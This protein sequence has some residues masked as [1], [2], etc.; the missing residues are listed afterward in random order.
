MIRVPCA[1]GNVAASLTIR[2]IISSQNTYS[3]V[4]FFFA[5][6]KLSYFM[7]FFTVKSLRE[8]KRNLKKADL[9]DSI[10]KPS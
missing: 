3:N 10:N 5:L 8:T 6:C 1:H 4:G 2:I 7:Y 9:K